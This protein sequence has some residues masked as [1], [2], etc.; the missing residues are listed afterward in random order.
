MKTIAALLLMTTAAAAQDCTHNTCRN[1]VFYNML[2]MTKKPDG[3][4]W[5]SFRLKPGGCLRGPLEFI[6][7]DTKI[8]FSLSENEDYPSGCSLRAF[9]H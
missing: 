7:A 8:V 1:A 9:T 2:V 3:S 5:Q 4:E 6:D